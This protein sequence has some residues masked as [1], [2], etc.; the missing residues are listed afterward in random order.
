MLGVSLNDL[1]RKEDALND[2]TKAIKI[3]PQYAEAYNNRGRYY[4]QYFL[5][6][7]L[8]DLGWE[9]DELNDS[10][11]AIQIDPQYA[12]AYNNRGRNYFNIL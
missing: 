6:N 9:E 10:T 8:S 5:R 1:G 4:H 3:N 12:E 2:Y 11:K 7:S